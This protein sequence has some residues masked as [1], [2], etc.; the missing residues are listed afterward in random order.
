MDKPVKLEQSEIKA[1]ERTLA[2]G[3]RVELI[4]VKDGAVRIVKVR[5]EEIKR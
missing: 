4:P 5:R 3:E 1:I 2:K